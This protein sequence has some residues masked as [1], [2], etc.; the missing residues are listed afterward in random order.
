M[1]CIPWD[2][3]SEQRGIGRGR[4]CRQPSGGSVPEIY[5][6]FVRWSRPS[7]SASRDR[8]AAHPRWAGGRPALL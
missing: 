8:P 5:D 7:S 1:T 4:H 6:S 2:D 3:V